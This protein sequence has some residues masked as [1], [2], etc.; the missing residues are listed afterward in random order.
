M[1]PHVYKPNLGITFYWE[2]LTNSQTVII[3]VLGKMC[4]G[5]EE[6]GS[7]FASFAGSN[8]NLEHTVYEKE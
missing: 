6:L 5:L 7:N 3:I 1:S 4:F 2:S 8:T